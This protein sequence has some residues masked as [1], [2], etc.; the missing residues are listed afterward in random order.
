MKV[1]ATTH[2]ESNRKAHYEKD[3]MEASIQDNARLNCATHIHTH[4]NKQTRKNEE[5]SM[6]LFERE[7]RN[8]KITQASNSHGSQDRGTFR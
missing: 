2:I 5:T 6:I 8:K 3:E 7:E 4:S 1:A